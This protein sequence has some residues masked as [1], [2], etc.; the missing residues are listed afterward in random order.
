[1]RNLFSFPLIGLL[2]TCSVP[3]ALAATQT[4]T[5]S[6]AQGES[7]TIP[8]VRLALNVG[9]PIKMP[10]GW[11]IY[12]GWLDNNTL[13]EVDGDRPFEQGA[14]ILYLV[15]RAA[16]AGKLSMMVRDPNGMDRLFVLKLVSG[17]KSSPDMVVVRDN[18]PN[19][20]AV[21]TRERT[22]IDAIRQGMDVAVEQG[23]LI[24]GS[25]LWT[26]IESFNRLVVQGTSS[27]VAARQT[28]VNLAV[29]KQLLDLVRASSPPLLPVPSNPVPS[30]ELDSASRRLLTPP[31]LTARLPETKVSE[32]P[33]PDFKKQFVVTQRKNQI[34]ELKPTSKP[35]VVAS[36]P[37]VSETE[38][39]TK[40]E[41]V[42][43]VASSSEKIE[44]TPQPTAISEPIKPR[45][46]KL[47]VV[48]KLTRK[49]QTVASVP[50]PETRSA[51]TS[52]V[53]PL[54][55]VYPKKSEPVSNHVLANGIVRGLLSPKNRIAKRGTY[56]Y[57]RFQDLVW[58]LR[59]GKPFEI[60]CGQA[61]VK[62]EAAQ[63]ILT[64]GGINL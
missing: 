61:R 41:P 21:K 36:A 19:V 23:R 44:P 50:T 5:G 46:A 53:Q 52:P 10:Q 18:S 8:T 35:Q 16:G 38:L 56:T 17:S 60:A 9:L 14:S 13:A 30:N 42:K 27:D 22:P 28:G 20:L 15:G 26:A 24:R 43:T 25:D 47:P 33:V 4:I 31:T 7:G 48:R 51:E 32:I 34:T 59:K 12:K 39:E 6:Q 1:M 45:I 37:S 58:L 57:Q 63:K 11:R 40:S 3:A 64:Y 55:S 2:L 62:P 29:I 49:P 54:D